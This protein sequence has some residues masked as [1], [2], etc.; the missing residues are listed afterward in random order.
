MIRLITQVSKDKLSLKLSN[1]FEVSL[2]A[3]KWTI[4]YV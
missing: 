1:H 3:L 4:E 2:G